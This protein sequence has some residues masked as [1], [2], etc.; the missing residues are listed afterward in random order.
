MIFTIFR[1]DKPL[2]K[3]MLENICA[4]LPSLLCR[5]QGH[6]ITLFFILLSSVY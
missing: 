6:L 1:Y 4:N 5:F 3:K 2:P